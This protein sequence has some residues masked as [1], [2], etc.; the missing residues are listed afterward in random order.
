EVA[1]E[2]AETPME[3]LG[4]RKEPFWAACRL[5]PLC[6]RS[7]RSQLRH[8][9]IRQVLRLF[10]PL[11]GRAKACQQRVGFQDAVEDGVHFGDVG[12][13]GTRSLVRDRFGSLSGLC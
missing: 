8:E 5:S 7:A 1:P 9:N 13:N 10:Q 6:G 11:G 4:D 2:A 3:L 12:A